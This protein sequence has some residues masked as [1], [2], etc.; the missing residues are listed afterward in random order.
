MPASY[1]VRARLKMMDEQLHLRRR[2]P[3]RNIL[4][5]QRP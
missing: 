3:I 2:L 5:F 4:G 1:S